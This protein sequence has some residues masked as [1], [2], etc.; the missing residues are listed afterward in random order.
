MRALA[1]FLGYHHREIPVRYSAWELPVT[2]CARPSLLGLSAATRSLIQPP[3]PDLL[4]TAGRR[5]EAAARWIATTSKGSTKLVQLGRPWHHP[6]HFDLVLTT[7]QYMVPRADNVI[8]LDLPLNSPIFESADSS[9]FEHLPR[10]HLVLLIGGHSGALTLHQA[11]AREL[12]RH[13]NRLSNALSG[14]LL[15]STSARTPASTMRLL[16]GLQAPHHLW[17]WGAPS[18]PYRDY[19]ASADAVIVTSDSVSMLADSLASAKPVLIFDLSDR[20]WWRH[21]QSFRLNALTHRLAMRLAPQ[22][23][24][25]DLA[26]IHHRMV[27]AGHAEWLSED[28]EDL[29]STTPFENRDLERAVTAVRRLVQAEPPN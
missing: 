29:P 1:H 3:W 7:P 23:M 8:S 13:A 11:L 12:L 14:S 4:L 24:R 27:A 17:R 22:R 18:N 20:K 9:R 16:E 25:R 28:V 19:L 26:R 6:R 5:N 2:L 15:V 10:P 21:L